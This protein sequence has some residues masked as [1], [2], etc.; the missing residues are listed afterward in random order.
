MTDTHV[1]DKSKAIFYFAYGSNMDS[2]RMTRRGIEVKNSYHVILHGWRLVFN[3]ASASKKQ[4]FANIEPGSGVVEGIVYEITEKDIE[5]LD[6]FEGY[7]THYIRITLEVPVDNELKRVVV[8]I[9]REEMITTNLLPSKK[10]LDFLLAA[11]RRLSPEYVARLINQ[12]TC[13]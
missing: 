3:K 10:Y 6:S 2:E 11:R 9:A 13:D 8:Y 1:S 5:L 7:L 12:P 4:A